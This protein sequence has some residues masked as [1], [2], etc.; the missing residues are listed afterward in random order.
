M[1]TLSDGRRVDVWEQ[2]TV[3]RS[4]VETM[5]MGSPVA[6]IAGA[7]ESSWIDELDADQRFMIG[8]EID[9]VVAGLVLGQRR[10]NVQWAAINAI[11][12]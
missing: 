1:L 8:C 7:W 12:V 3:V 4:D 2:P 6:S 5:I 11:E 10:G 9:S